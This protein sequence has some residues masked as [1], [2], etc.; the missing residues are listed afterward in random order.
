MHKC[1]RY[2]HVAVD[3]GEAAAA[4]PGCLFIMLSRYA[5]PVLMALEA[6]CLWEFWCQVS[7]LTHSTQG[8]SMLVTVRSRWAKSHV[9]L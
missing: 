3:C 1:T 9:V 2:K 7:V 5:V 8:C 4:Y 6:V